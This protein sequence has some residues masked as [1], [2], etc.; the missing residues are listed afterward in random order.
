MKLLLVE[1]D[2]DIS[3]FIHEGLAREG[4]AVSRVADGKSALEIA[5]E[6]DFDIILLDVMM[7]ELD[8]YQV[9]KK[10]RSQ[11]NQTPVLM[12]TCKGQE[13][14][15]LQ[16]FNSGAD[17]YIVKPFVL[18]EV[19]ARIRAILRR[20]DKSPAK[21]T[22]A[23]LLKAGDIQLDLLKREAKRG[24]KPVELTKKEFDL[25][26]CFMRRPGQVLSQTVLNQHLTQHDFATSTNT[27]EVHIKN[28][29]AKIDGKSGKSFLRT[30][31]GCGY[32]LD[33]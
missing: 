6:E 5:G 3:D 8:G 10:L 24:G 15:K 31:R 12:I 22:H 11:G 27:I 19:I 30:V 18:S 4:I 26:E 21:G 29:R 9:L 16:G 33:V 23:T 13:R 32:A 7:P 20:M 17:D 1:D 25:L 2:K 28:L 14:D